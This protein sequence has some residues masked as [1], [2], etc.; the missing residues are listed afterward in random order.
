VNGDNVSCSI[1]GQVVGTYTKAALMS[2]GLKSTDG[3]YGL[4]FGHNTDVKVTGFG[5]TKN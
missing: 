1:N 2:A 3:V 5:M 4:R